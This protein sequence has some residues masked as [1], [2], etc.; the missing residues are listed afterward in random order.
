MV[1]FINH[2]KSLEDLTQSEEFNNHMCPQLLVLLYSISIPISHWNAGFIHPADKKGEN[3]CAPG[4]EVA[5]HQNRTYPA[6]D[7][8][9]SCILFAHICYIH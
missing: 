5:E 3:Q 9:A 7:Y 1:N 4:L 2:M 8:P 6:D